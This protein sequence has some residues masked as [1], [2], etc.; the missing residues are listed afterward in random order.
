MKM[1]K[2]GIWIANKRGTFAIADIEDRYVAIRDVMIDKKGAFIYGR[3]RII[4]IQD[5]DNYKVL[6]YFCFIVSIFDYS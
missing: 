1:I 3:K 4:G 6:D 5:L 2:K